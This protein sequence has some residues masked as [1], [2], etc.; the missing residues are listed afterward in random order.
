MTLDNVEIYSCPPDVPI[1]GAQLV[2]RDYP[3]GERNVV[4]MDFIAEDRSIIAPCERPALFVH[5][6]KTMCP[7]SLS[8][9]IVQR[10][11]ML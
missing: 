7:I 9:A 8:G 2:V 3:S 10:S 11:C 5:F 1:F 4:W 6:S